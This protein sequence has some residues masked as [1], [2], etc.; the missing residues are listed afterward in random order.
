MAQAQRQSNLFAA[1]DFRTIYRTFSQINFTA[2]DFDTIKEAMV[3]YLQN[4]FPEDF[5]DFIESSEFIAIVEL[6]AYMGQT[7]AFRQDL[8][9]REN[10]LDTAERKE[11]VLRLANMLNYT[12][13]RNI[14]GTGLIKVHAIRTTQEL[15]DSNGTTLSNQS[16]VWNDPNNTDFLEQFILILNTA[17]IPQNPY[18]TPVKK[19]TLNT[20]ATEVYHINVVTN[21]KVV[22]PIAATVNGAAAPLELVNAIFDDD[23]YIREV[24]PDPASSFGLLYLN[25][26]LGNA[27]AS[28]GF[29]G[30]AKQGTLTYQDFNLTVPMPNREINIDVENINEFDVWVQTINAAGII[31]DNWIKVPAISGT[32]VIYN[33]V[34]QDTRKIFK[35][36]T[37]A[38]DTVS[39]QFADGNF[40]DVPYGIVRVW[41]RT[42]ANKQLIIK[43]EDVGLQ[44]IQI[45][46][47]DANGSTQVLSATMQLV[48]SIG[49]SLGSETTTEIKTNASRTFYTQDRM[50]TGEDYNIYPMF[51]NSNILKMKAVNRTHSG[52]SRSIDINDPTGTVQ[53]LNVFAE[54][55]MLYKDEQNNELTFNLTAS[56]TAN[57]IIQQHLQPQLSLNE[58]TNFYY[59]TYRKEV[60]SKDGSLA[61]K[62]GTT[63]Q[64]QWVTLPAAKEFSKGYFV[65]NNATFSFGNAMAIGSIASGKRAYLIEKCLL[66]FTDSTGTIIEYATIENIINNGDPTGRSSGAVELNKEIP[67]GYIL[68][69]FFPTFRRIFNQ[70]EKT[71]ITAQLDLKNTFGIGFDY[72]T[73][74]FYSIAPNNLNLTDTTYKQTNAQDNTSDNKDASWIIKAQYQA[75]T[76]T[77]AA[78]YLITTRGLRYVFESEEDVRFYFN[79]AYKTI[80]I[81]TGKAKKDLVSLL[82]VN[83][84]KRAQIDNISITNPGAGY[85]T[86]P[87]L[88]FS[89]SGEVDDAT[90]ISHL[91]WNSVT[92]GTGGVGYVP[93]NNTLTYLDSSVV[94]AD[95][96]ATEISIN[97]AG[98]LAADGRSAQIRANLSINA[99]ATI[100]METDAVGS[101]ILA[102]GGTLWT[103]QPTVTITAPSS[104]TQ[105]T[106]TAIISQAL[107]GFGFNA[108]G[109]QGGGYQN[110]P[111]VYIDTPGFTGAI[112][113][114]THN[115]VQ[116]YVNFEFINSSNQLISAVYNAPTVTFIDPNTLKVVWDTATTGYMNIIKSR[117]GSGTLVPSGNIWTITHGLTGTSG[118]IN[119]DLVDSTGVSLQGRESFPLIE[120]TTDTS[121]RVIFPI[122][123]TQT[124]YALGHNSAGNTGAVGSGYL[125][126]QSSAATTWTVSHNLGNK[127]CSVDVAVL[128]S[129]VDD[130]AFTAT[131]DTTLYYNIK[132]L[133]DY[134]TVVFTDENTLTLTFATAIA[135]KAMITYGE[136]LELGSQEQAVGIPHMEVGDDASVP[137]GCPPV[138]INNPGTGFVASDVGKVYTVSHGSP[139][140]G[141]GTE[142]TVTIAS[143]WLV[144]SHKTMDTFGAANVSRTAGTYTGVTGTSGGSGTVGT[145][146][147]VVG[148]GGAVT[149]AVVA[150]GGSGHAVNDTITIADSS[151]GSGG[152]AAFTMDVATISSTAEVAS[153]TLTTGG[154]YTALPAVIGCT[155][156]KHASATGDGLT[157]DLNFKVKSVELSPA[158]DGYQTTPTVTIG[159]PTGTCGTGTT[160]TGTPTLNGAVIAVNVTNPGT[161]YSS[162]PTIGFVRHASDTTGTGAIATS[163]LS[164]SVSGVTITNSGTGY[165]SASPPT[166]TFLAPTSPGVGITGVTATG[167]AIVNA[168]GNLT[169]ITITSG[170]TG[171]GSP[172]DTGAVIT[173][174]PSGVIQSMEMVDTGYGYTGQ[175]FITY[176]PA[177]GGSGASQISMKGFV[178][179]VQLTDIGSGYLPTDTLTFTAPTTAGSLRATGL[180]TTR[181]TKNFTSDIKFNM[182]DL[183]TYE[184]GYQ[185]PKKALITF[186]DS[187]NDMVPDDPLSFDKFVNTNRY[188]FQETY[189][190]FDGYVYYKLTKNVLEAINQ[191]QENTILSNGADYVGK[192][193]YRSDLK[194]FKKIST[195]SPYT[196]TTLT[197]DADGTTKFKAY[198]GRSRHVTPTIT[199]TAVVDQVAEDV[200]FQWKHY[201]P[202]D[203]RVDPS[204]TNLID[205]FVLTRIYHTNVLAWKANNSPIGE[206][207]VVP[208]TTELAVS[209]DTL[210]TYKSISDEIIYKPVKFKLLFGTDALSE[211][212]ATFKIIKVIGSTLSDNELRSQ[213]VAT[214]N[215]FFSIENWELGE[216]FYYTELAAYIH[217]NLSSHL[218]SIVIVPTQAESNF[219]NLFQV[220]AEANELFLSTATVSDVEVVKG[221]TEQNLKIR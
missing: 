129:N 79:N 196:A 81:K 22:Y 212:Q 14:P 202:V 96:N 173:I 125:H 216:S 102:T 153:V 217:Q 37:E 203:Q 104:G 6:L 48:T 67:H 215:T 99:A 163:A 176:P 186:F 198:I 13:K 88:T 92:G 87:T 208:T 180:I 46:Y 178:S 30:Y 211:L 133:Y 121:C 40:G 82:K 171:Y 35:V 112:W 66:E 47:V 185:D 214:T 103:A 2:Y 97:N 36:N 200:F 194:V 12:P 146:N 10:F 162:N 189:T 113:N 73:S 195:T 204:A 101:I 165:I 151:L 65:L 109:H 84:D 8:N 183:L 193:I 32:N 64:L 114:V 152:A 199:A 94:D 166:V 20:I 115:H 124:G 156:T 140:V 126:T 93:S 209:M 95:D 72:K 138:T 188:M 143:V 175:P 62:L 160:S 63:E 131:I 167:T 159:A 149:S 158:G 191:T 43:T 118:I 132:G 110:I 221:F 127:H 89:A 33:S 148:A 106:A 16:I 170:G 75:A 74:A 205:I 119:L 134:P 177:A 136:V 25:D 174:A 206:F 78:T 86:A 142:A 23:L 111:S 54:D 31:L 157:L 192:Y 154:D 45:P 19:G 58:L 53:N 184:D 122:G 130:T 21:Q 190:D 135:G 52:H 18:G 172:A 161:G 98:V 11:S 179:R 27:S 207:P 164:N 29:F 147:I 60:Q 116:R 71:S 38:D 68:T 70:V 220:K 117:Y 34:I 15:T 28:T 201:A 80:D 56:L 169:G 42:S 213:V 108:P 120:Y 50:I 44:T 41:Y 155:T 59:D 7:I 210:S 105:A 123:V 168:A 107:T 219:G 137:S 77:T 128:G 69:R 24:A 17:F 187:D 90:A 182:S 218:S 55:G 150:T 145:F 57:T 83:V 144:G 141:V 49:N 39:I 1:E 139:P 61:W 100:T 26:G 3:E 85:Q 51:K 91:S 197:N 5:N 76:S 4:N 181:A 9:V